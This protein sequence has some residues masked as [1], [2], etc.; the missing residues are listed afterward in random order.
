MKKFL[1]VALLFSFSSIM[2]QQRLL[3]DTHNDVFSFQLVTKAD[4]GKLQPV[5]NFDLIRAAKGGLN[6][7]VFSIWCGEDY[8]KGKGFAHANRE[9]D[10]LYA[11]IARYP[12]KMALVKSPQELKKVHQQG[13]FAAMIGVE[14]GHMIEDRMDYLD[15]LIKRGLV[16]LTL[17]WNNS[18]SWASSARDETTGKGMRQAGLNELGKQIVKTLNKNGVLVDVSHAGERTFY[19]VLATSTKPVIAS[20]SNAY[21]L[22]PHRRNLK[23][24][25]LKALAKNGGVVFVNF[26]SGFLDSSYDHRVQDFLQLHKKELD[27]L[28][29]IYTKDFAPTMLN[30]MYKKE[31]DQIRPPLSALVKHIDYMVK[32]IGVDHVGIGSDFDGSES[33]PAGMDSVADYPKLETALK[34][35][36]YKKE[37]IDKIFGGNFV[38]VWEASKK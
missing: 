20:H 26:Y 37:W 7:Q 21:A 13:R 1:P 32:L 6:A 28:N 16:Y 10:S 2:A 30:V 33:F 38:R 24:E 9:I 3:V 11:L 34:N 15:S 18:T 12:D 27:S 22:T 31:A 17:T 35:I 4:L 5:G 19:D 8:G 25:Q 29:N 14:G 23:D 36:G